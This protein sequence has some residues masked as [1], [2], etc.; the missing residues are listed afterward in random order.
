MLGNNV[1]MNNPAAARAPLHLWI[2]V[3]VAPL[4]W[5]VKAMLLPAG[6]ERRLTEIAFL[7][8]AVPAETAFDLLMIPFRRSEFAFEFAYG[9]L[10]LKNVLLD[11]TPIGGL[12]WIAMLLAVWMRRPMI[13]LPLYAV[14]G[15]VWSY[16]L[17]LVQIV[18]TVWTRVHWD[19]DLASGWQLIALN[20]VCFAT[21]LG[22]QLA[23]DRFI[24][25]IFYPVPNDHAFVQQMTAIEFSWNRLF[26]PLAVVAQPAPVRLS[27]GKSRLPTLMSLLRFRAPVG[28][29]PRTASDPAHR[30]SF[31]VLD[32]INPLYWFHSCKQFLVRW[33]F[34]RA[35]TSLGPGVPAM[36]AFS[37]LSML[38]LVSLTGNTQKREAVYAAVL[39]HALEKKDFDSAAIAI[40]TLVD[41]HPDNLNHRYQAA[42]LE[43]LRGN[44]QNSRSQM[45]QLAE[46]ESHGMAAMWLVSKEFD[47]Q[48]LKSWTE[49]DHSKF[50]RLMDIALSDIE[51]DNLLSAK[52][53]MFSY[54]VEVGAY[55][56]A[57][58]FISEVVPARQE[59]ALP[60]AMLCRSLHDDTGADK[61]RKQAERYFESMLSKRPSDS[62]VRINLARTLMFGERFEEAATL[63]NDGYRLTKDKQLAAVAAEAL[64][65]W[66]DHLSKAK[67]S[68][69]SLFKRLQILRAAMGI[70]PNDRQVANALAVAMIESHDNSTPEV[71]EIRS[72]I[73]ASSDTVSHQFIAG[74]LAIMDDDLDKGISL[75][76]R[77]N[78]NEPNVPAILNNLAVAIAES[79]SGELGKALNFSNAALAQNPNHPYFLET[80]GQILVKLGRWHEAIHDLERAMAAPKLKP[81]ILPSLAIAYRGIGSSEMAQQLEA[82]ATARK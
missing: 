79:K 69:K 54:L 59:L 23:T 9:N 28:I 27:I 32:C 76:E 56:E 55:G 67:D 80:R 71:A 30:V 65:V 24:Q 1:S 33:L 37:G 3:L 40:A 77:A 17:S 42:M 25:V 10:A 81:Q 11:L 44:S 72:A 82:L 70:A 36:M 60:A 35:Y 38:S 8:V 53:L 46:S 13:L 12:F 14:A 4:P 73:L 58:R 26:M 47:L 39:R 2:I 57:K 7:A 20:C 48:K 49:K 41:A 45:M 63:M 22:L 52:V 75:L 62:E 19:W 5:L 51:D 16:G 78:Q 31:D 50:R 61:Y 15:L 74:T 18:V 34:S 64:L 29:S 43:H 21:A 66:S 6:F 68:S